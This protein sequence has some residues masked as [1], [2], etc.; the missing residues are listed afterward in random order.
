[1]AEPAGAQVADHYSDHLVKPPEQ[2]PSTAARVALADPGSLAPLFRL[3]L[4]VIPLF[5]VPLLIA[6][7]VFV[8]RRLA[9]LERAA[10]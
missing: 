1:M 10:A 4:V 5:A 6:S 9:Q 3:P 7:H 2:M 8:F